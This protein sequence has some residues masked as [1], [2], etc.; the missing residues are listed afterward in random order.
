LPL[1]L[2]IVVDFIDPVYALPSVID[3]SLNVEAAVE[4]LS[5]PTSMAFLDENYTLILEKEGNVRLVAN[6]ILK[7][8]PILQIPVSTE[9]ERGLLGI[10]TSNGSGG[11][12]PNDMDVFLYSTAGDPLRNRIYKY[13]WNGETLINPQ[14][15]LDL[16]AEPG[17]NHDG[18]KIVI[19]PDVCSHRRSKS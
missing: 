7:E 5:S 12:S 4:E 10:A 3:T 19:G 8:Q 15:I 17:P 9:N 1:T 18:R 2:A 6:G 14:L 13:Q 11:G 16:P